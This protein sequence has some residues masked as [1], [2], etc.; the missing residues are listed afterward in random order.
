MSAVTEQLGDPVDVF[1]RDPQ[2]AWTA[3]HV[4]VFAT[5]PADRRRVDDR[6]QLLEVLDEQTE[7]QRLVPVPKGREA[8]VPL[9]V[10]ALATEV[11]ELKCHL[12]LDRRNSPG[13]QAAECERATF[14]VGERGILI[15]FWSR[16]E[17][18]PKGPLGI[19]RIGHRLRLRIGTGAVRHGRT[20]HTTHATTGSLRGEESNV[21][22]RATIFSSALSALARNASL[23][24]RSGKPN[25]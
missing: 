8:D 19:R 12:L 18:P 22:G 17:R 3:H 7:E 1:G 9:E 11:L 25:R 20:V 24:V 2:P 16:K 10:V 4:A 14:F 5:G 15:R 21:L 13:E 23:P 6:R